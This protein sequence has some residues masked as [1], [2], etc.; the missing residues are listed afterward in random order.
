M[1]EKRLILETKTKQL[2]EEVEDLLET[3]QLKR[4]VA[5]TTTIS[6]TIKYRGMW[7][8]VDEETFKEKVENEGGEYSFV[9]LFN[10]EEQLVW[11]IKEDYPTQ[12]V[13][14]SEYGIT[15]TGDEVREKDEITVVFFDD[16]KYYGYLQADKL[17]DTKEYN[18]ISFSSELDVRLEL[19]R[20]TPEFVHMVTRRTIIDCPQHSESDIW[21]FNSER[22]DFDIKLILA[23]YEGEK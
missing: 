4:K 20:N 23:V 11:Y 7:I 9:A 15:I 17:V 21:I 22:K 16:I 6:Q 5:T 8:T 13:D 12:V 1:E 19:A 18:F 2:N 14:L 10:N 3:D